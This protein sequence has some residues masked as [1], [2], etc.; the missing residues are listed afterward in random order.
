MQKEELRKVYPHQIGVVEGEALVSN[1][2]R[3]GPYLTD[4]GENFRLTK[5]TDPLTLTVD[6]ALA[7]IEKADKKKSRKK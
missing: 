4:R 3:F 2:G 7:I 5:G 6:Q 1:I